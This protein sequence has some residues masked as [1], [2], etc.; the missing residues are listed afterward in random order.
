MF[1]R[2]VS[3]VLAVLVAASAAVVAPAPAMAHPRGSIH[4]VDGQPYL[5]ANQNN[6]THRVDKTPFTV[7]RET[8]MGMVRFNTKKG[9]V[10]LRTCDWK[11]Q[12]GKVNY[13]CQQK[14]GR[15]LVAVVPRGENGVDSKD[16]A[17]QR[18]EMTC[19]GRKR[20]LIYGFKKELLLHVH[21]HT[22][23][24]TPAEERNWVRGVKLTVEYPAAKRLN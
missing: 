9:A 15:W 5:C 20:T 1:K 7:S 6:A 24:G 22:G 2:S 4:Y 12:Y 11:G 19:D 13:T 23:K 8:V 14:T 21:L 16:F 3:P 17:A 18:I 10:S